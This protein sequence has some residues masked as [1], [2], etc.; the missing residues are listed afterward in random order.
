MHRFLNDDGSGRLPQYMHQLMLENRQ[1]STLLAVIAV[2]L[3][4]I[5]GLLLYRVF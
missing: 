5:A 1:Q 2:A 3:T 4:L